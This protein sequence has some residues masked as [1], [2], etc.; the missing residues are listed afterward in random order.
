MFGLAEE[1]LKAI[2]ESLKSENPN[3]RLKAALSV[4]DR[5]VDA[6]VGITNP[7]ELIRHKCTE[8]DDWTAGF[9]DN[10]KLDSERFQQL[11][12]ENNLTE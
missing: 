2:K 10:Q 3:V 8:E 12:K 5:I 11:L 1:A 6:D 7:V 4:I 9:F